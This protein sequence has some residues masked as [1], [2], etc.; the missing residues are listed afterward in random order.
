MGELITQLFPQSLGE[1][2][3][4]LMGEPLTQCLGEPLGE[5]IP[6]PLGELF[7]Q[8]MGELVGELFG[9]PLGELIPQPF[10]QPSEEPL[11]VAGCGRAKP[12]G[13]ALPNQ[14]P[15]DAGCGAELPFVSLDQPRSTPNCPII[16]VVLALVRD[17]D[18]L[19]RTLN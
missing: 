6:Q 1:P 9:E 13:S 15:T 8:F 14:D 5:F 11:S 19:I 18:H 17:N 4:E 2:L 7:T 16:E 3:G 10:T 12:G